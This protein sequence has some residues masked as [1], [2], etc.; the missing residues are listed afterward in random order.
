MSRSIPKD[1]NTHPNSLYVF[2]V[3]FLAAFMTLFIVWRSPGIWYDVQAQVVAAD[4][5]LLATQ[6]FVSLTGQELH[7]TDFILASMQEAKLI[8]GELTAHLKSIAERIGRRLDVESGDTEDGRATLFLTIETQN[9]QAAL[10]LLDA[11][12]QRAVKTAKTEM[13]AIPAAILGQRGGSIRP[14]QLIVL[15]VL[16]SIIGFCGVWLA[17]RARPSPVLC[18][19]QEVNEAV[20]LPVLASLQEPVGKRL[21]H[22]S[23]YRRSILRTLLTTAECGISAVLLWMIFQFATVNA[24]AARFYSDPL[25]AYGEAL[26]RISS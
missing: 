5:E 10:R 4:M 8:Q 3:L 11:M 22:A 21:F 2:L 26:S 14:G 18:S 7:D 15:A 9:F 6:E 16:S 24:F 20:G 12:T 25:A 23:A 19:E 13:V 1:G 17:V